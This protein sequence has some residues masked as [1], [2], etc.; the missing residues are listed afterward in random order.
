V[1]AIFLS[2]AAM[3]AFAVPATAATYPAGFEEREIV[4]GLDRP[5][6]AAWAPDGRMFVV[7][8]DGALKV[9]EPG[10]A[11]AIP[12]AD[13]SQR[14]NS[15]HDRGLLGVA[16]D[17]QYS[18]TNPFLYLLYTYDLNQTIP[19]SEGPMVSQLMRV[20]VD[21][22]NVVTEPTVI[23]GTHMSGTCPPP[24]NNID[25]MPSDGLSHSIGTVRSAP[26]G[27]VWLGSG[28]AASF[29]E[30]DRTALRTYDERSLAGKIIHVDRF[31]RGIG[32]HPFCPGDTNLANVCT[33]LHAKGFR[34]PFRFTL[35]PGGG[36]VVGDV[37][38][39]QKEE[40]DL[41]PAAGG[42]SYGWPCYEGT[43]R[44]P[45]YSNLAECQAEYNRPAGTHLGPTIDYQ[46]NGSRSVM[47][48]PEYDGT[49]YPADYR[50]SIFYADY[51]G[52]FVRRLA[53]DGAGYRD[54]PFASSWSGVAV[55]EAPNGDLVVVDPG[56]FGD[57]QGAV[58]RVA[59]GPDNRTP[60][61][62]LSATPTSGS[63][64][65]T[66]SFDARTSSD[67]DGDPLTY[68]WAFGDGESAAG[69]TASHT[70]APGDYTAVLTVDDGRGRTGTAQVR[71]SSGNTAPAVT[72]SGDSAYRGGVPFRLS[73]SGDDAED[74]ELPA[75]AFDWDVKLFHADHIHPVGNYRDRGAIEMNAITDH[76]ADAFY[77]V[78]VT[79][80]DSG[81]TSTRATA[82][83][84]PQTT[85][86]RLDSSPP[87]A[88]LSYGGRILTAPRD[89]TSA[90]GFQTSVSAAQ[91]FVA[92]GRR[93][94]FERWSDNGALVHDI[95]IPAGAS[96]LIAHYRDTSP[97]PAAPTS[98]AG[99]G[100]DRKGPKLRLLSVDPV[101]GRL[102]GSAVDP[103]G[104]DRVAVALRRR[105]AGK[106]CSWWLSRR[107][108][109]S[110]ASR[111]CGRPLW[112]K[113]RLGRAS[114]GVRW[115]VRLRRALPPGR[116]RILV[117]GVDAAGNGA[118][119]SSGRS[120]LV[121]VKPAGSGARRA[122]AR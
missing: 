13:F 27:T 93:Y 21:A 100:R 1:R 20:R 119:L 38:W 7:E 17:G 113:A 22:N 30:V 31:G 44:T 47:G 18:A 19:D 105:P 33:K 46:H 24:A 92:N 14:V 67:P 35:R 53:P 39:D 85:A 89:L 16:V 81:G 120:T 55:E 94:V 60:V 56:Q 78:I 69:S 11:A 59:Y 51:S 106:G 77:E 84:R 118:M 116:Y 102:R 28:D 114:E 23:L 98:P 43:I 68:R 10:G 88:P 115:A 50:N 40:V 75:T 107:R 71:I 3:L 48:G 117:K 91:S 72:I 62:R 6:A 121:R 52:G 12:I 37:G 64:P 25:C 41:V 73:A 65:L 95:T 108:R 2:L 112:I 97:A 83:L 122:S 15:H 4:A 101:R 90:I 74:G 104:V 58:R 63:A 34:N 87:G 110:S 49:L 29:S 86:F 45:G 26:D 32:S 54:E 9:V 79:A 109:M 66:V 61:A 42:Q 57:G 8:K 36:L 82:R 5:M 76:D 96:G 70:Y 99:P 111:S 80:T 103:S